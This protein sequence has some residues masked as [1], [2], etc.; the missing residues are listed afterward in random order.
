MSGNDAFP[1]GS[2]LC[3]FIGDF[4]RPVVDGNRKSFALHA[5]DEVFPHYREANEADVRCVCHMRKIFDLS[6]PNLLR[7]G[8]APSSETPNFASAVLTPRLRPVVLTAREL[9]RAGREATS[10]KP[11]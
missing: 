6:A 7:P 9:H 2:S 8:F 1:F 11:R 4:G 5:Q 10:G 3:E